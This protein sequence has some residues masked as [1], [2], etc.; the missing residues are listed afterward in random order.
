MKTIRVNKQGIKV[1]GFKKKFALYG[2][3]AYGMYRIELK[4]KFLFGDQIVTLYKSKNKPRFRNLSIINFLAPF[5]TLCYFV[6]FWFSIP[7]ILYWECTVNLWKGKENYYSWVS[8]ILHFIGFYSLLGYLL[9][10]WI[11]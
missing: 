5:I 7:F 11:F 9:V 2:K 6:C 10:K 1:F 4:N 3:N 8:G